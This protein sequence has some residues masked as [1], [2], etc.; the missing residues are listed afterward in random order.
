M[1]TCGQARRER[2]LKAFE[3]KSTLAAERRAKEVERRSKEMARRQV[4][5]P[6]CILNVE[7][8]CM[9]QIDLCLTKCD[10]M[11]WSFFFIMTRRPKLRLVNYLCEGW[12]AAL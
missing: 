1:T 7:Q 11:Q 2:N 6:L 3:N 5:I 4:T 8:R 10:E 12:P 9:Y